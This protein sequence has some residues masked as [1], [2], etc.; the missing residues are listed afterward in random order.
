MKLKLAYRGI[1]G[2]QCIKNPVSLYIKNCDLRTRVLKNTRIYCSM[3]L[4]P[5][6]PSTLH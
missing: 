6:L 2:S 1:K 4:P 3:C 5:Y